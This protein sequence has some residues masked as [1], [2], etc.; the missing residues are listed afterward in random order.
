M[1]QNVAPCISLWQFQLS[2]IPSHYSQLSQSHYHSLLQIKADLIQAKYRALLQ[3]NSISSDFLQILTYINI[4]Q[5][6]RNSV[7]VALSHF[8]PFKKKLRGIK[9]EKLYL[10]TPLFPI[11]S[12][13]LIAYY[14]LLARSYHLAS[15]A[16]S[17]SISFGMAYNSRF[18]YTETLCLY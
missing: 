3:Q 4:C 5:K 10:C 17:L 1:H 12:S 9:K 13:F 6:S 2:L 18:A 8:M 11:H 7:T 14:F 15:L 16:F